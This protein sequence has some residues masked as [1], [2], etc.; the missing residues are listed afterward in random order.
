MTD[1][2]KI[3]E[4]ETYILNRALENYIKYNNTKIM[5]TALENLKKELEDYLTSAEKIDSKSKF[6]I[7]EI[8]LIVRDIDISIIKEKQNISTIKF[9]M[10]KFINIPFSEQNLVF[11]RGFKGRNNRNL[12]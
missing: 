10:C 1:K 8:R 11:S 5:V 12:W 3:L 2:N 4:T 9:I 6:K 7:N